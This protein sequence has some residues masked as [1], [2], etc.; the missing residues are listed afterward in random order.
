MPNQPGDTSPRTRPD[1]RSSPA[2]T[3]VYGCTDCRWLVLHKPTKDTAMTDC[4]RCNTT[5]QLGQLREL[6][7]ASSHARAA[8]YQG[9]LFADRADR[10]DD[11]Q[12]TP[13]YATIRIRFVS[14]NVSKLPLQPICIHLHLLNRF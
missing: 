3:A 10:L 9:R 14:T 12:D 6:Y 8:E 7:T 1:T 4:P 11:Y 2:Q 5:H 13:T